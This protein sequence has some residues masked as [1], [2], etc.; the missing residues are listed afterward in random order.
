[1]AIAL[2]EDTV[3]HFYKSCSEKL[4]EDLKRWI[5]M[6]GDFLKRLFYLFQPTLKSLF[7]VVAD[8][9]VT[10]HSNGMGYTDDIL[11]QVFGIDGKLNNIC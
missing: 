7:H 2:L 8:G 10:L 1:M 5:L 4:L 9:L 6:T 3:D 11:Q